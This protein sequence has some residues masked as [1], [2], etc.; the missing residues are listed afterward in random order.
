MAELHINNNKG[1]QFKWETWEDEIIKEIYPI[2][3][4]EDV[5][6][7]LPHRNKSG[8]QGRAFKLGIKYITYNKNYFEKINS[9]TKAYW[10]GFLYADGYVTTNNRWGLEL[11]IA[12][13]EH[14]KN[15]LSSFECNI[16]PKTRIRE[17]NESCLFQINNKKMYSDLVN[18]GV[19]RNK[20]EILQFPSENILPTSY[21]SHFIRGFFD[22]DGCITY[23]NNDYIRKDRNNKIYNNLRKTVFIVCKSEKFITALKNI[24]ASNNI[25]F[26]VYVDKEN[27]YTLQTSNK[28]NIVKF[29][30][31][32][33]QETDENIRLKRKYEK[34][35]ELLCHLQQ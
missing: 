22:G 23:S 15:L 17:G 21:Y 24:L 11:C 18:N 6:K 14:K 10:L 31:Y 25:L 9:P 30:S 32:I 34:F 19:L 13:I 2:H 8:I 7:L 5:L 12:D 1:W 4:Y 33:Y 28:E 35:Q 16:I 3:G 27:L 29:E 26:E 20:T